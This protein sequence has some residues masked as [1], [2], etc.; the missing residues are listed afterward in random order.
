MAAR[1]SSA[2]L[3]R[4]VQSRPKG[5]DT[6]LQN[7]GKAPKRAATGKPFEKGQSGNPKG[8]PPKGQATAD[9]LRAIGDLKY[10]GGEVTFRERA[11]RVLWEQAAKGDLHALQW[12]VERTEGKVPNT[13]EA[14]GNF[15]L[16]VLGLEDE[17]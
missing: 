7:S 17:K 2:P 10:Q 6:P 16:R 8:R 14:E 1:K 15:V 3:A 9:I 11:A 5:T 13:V 12:I 4:V